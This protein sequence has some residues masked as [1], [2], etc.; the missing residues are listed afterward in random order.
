[1]SDFEPNFF[2]N[3]SNLESKFLHRFRFRI[4]LFN[5]RK[6]WI[7]NFTM[8][9]ILK[10]NFFV[11]NRKILKNLLSR[12]QVLWVILHRE[13]EKIGFLALSRKSWFW[14]FL[15]KKYILSTK[16]LLASSHFESSFSKHVTFWT[17]TFEHV[18]FGANILNFANTLIEK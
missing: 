7:E 17:N 18:I 8:R 14:Y 13:N 15:W 5:T 10:E 6:V 9:Q 11:E 3:P 1:M 2:D 4:N 12:D 16:S